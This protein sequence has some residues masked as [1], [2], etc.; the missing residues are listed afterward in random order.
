[1][2]AA[3]HFSEAAFVAA[4]NA[5]LEKVKTILDNT[6]HPHWAAD[7]HHEYSDKYLLAEF[8]VNS[9][10]GAL[11]TCLHWLGLTEAQLGQL[12]EW[13]KKRTVSLQ[14]RAEE[15]CKL[16]RKTE[17]EVRGGARLGC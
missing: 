13:A 17:R 8:I 7:V 4:V 15:Q 9:T 1:M 5:A 11:L 2:S 3:V 16:L 12:R 10:I 6:R 14:L